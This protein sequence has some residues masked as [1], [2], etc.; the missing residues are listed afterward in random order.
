MQLHKNLVVIS[1]ICIIYLY[2]FVCVLPRY[3]H[4]IY[5]LVYSYAQCTFPRH[6]PNKVIELSLKTMQ[7]VILNIDIWIL[8][9]TS[10]I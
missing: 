2:Y 3:Q 8:L 4:C 1:L 9:F 7:H 5:R 10:T 6:F